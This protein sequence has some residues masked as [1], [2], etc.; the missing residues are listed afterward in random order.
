VRANGSDN[1]L[2]IFASP[3]EVRRFMKRG[4]YDVLHVMA[5]EVPP[6]AW[7]FAWFSGAAVRVATFHAYT[8]NEG[9]LSRFARRLICGPQLTLFDRGIAVSPSAA[10]FARGSWSRPLTLI[11]NGVDTQRF[12]P[13]G[14]RSRG[15]GPLKLLFVGHFRDPRKGLPVLLDAYDRLRARGVEARL[16]VVGAGPAQPAQPGVVYHGPISD[17]EALAKMYREG[18]MFV[19]PSMGMESFGIVLL[20]AMASGKPIVCS[21]NDGYRA[22]VPS[23]GAR[24]VAPGDAEGLA[25]AIAELSP[26]LRRKMGEINRQAALPYDWSRLAERVRE[27]YVAALEARGLITPTRA[28]QMTTSRSQHASTRP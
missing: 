28:R 27:E 16:D 8:E 15:E 26:E 19:A 11:P 17:E 18:D 1:W 22:V 5:P 24:L 23:E 9:A 10:Q 13:E 12:S 4:R 21:D 14:Q 6:L 3:L 7:Y 2:A 25:Q 20:E